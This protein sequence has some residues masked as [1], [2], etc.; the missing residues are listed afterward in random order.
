M[1]PILHDSDRILIEELTPRFRSVRRGEVIVFRHPRDPKRLLVKR[2]I[3]MGGDTVAIDRGL[4]ALNGVVQDEPYLGAGSRDE[5]SFA[6]TEVAHGFLYV[7]GDDRSISE[8]SRVWGPIPESTVLGRALFTYW[9][10]Q[11][12]RNLVPP[13]GLK[14]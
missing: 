10:P 6:P 12:G 4:V 13:R 7:L 14:P 11:R 9:P 5:R 8:D 3:G 2:V 1:L